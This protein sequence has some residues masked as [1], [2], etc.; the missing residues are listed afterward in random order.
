MRALTILARSELKKSRES[1][2][3]A[4]VPTVIPDWSLRKRGSMDAKYWLA[5]RYSIQSK[6]FMGGDDPHRAGKS[7]LRAA[8]STVAKAAL[9]GQFSASKRQRLVNRFRHY[10]RLR[11]RLFSAGRWGRVLIVFSHSV[12]P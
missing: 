7:P 12:F 3:V 10:G 1:F 4:A 8:R 5:Q 6:C 11:V 2:G 9:T